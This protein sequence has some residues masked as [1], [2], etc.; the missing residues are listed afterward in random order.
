MVGEIMALDSL[1]YVVD[2]FGVITDQ[3]IVRDGFIEYMATDRMIFRWFSSVF[4]LFDEPDYDSNNYSKWIHGVIRNEHGELVIDHNIIYKVFNDLDKTYELIQ[5]IWLQW[6]L[7]MINPRTNKGPV[8]ESSIV[9]LNKLRQLGA[10]LMFMADIVNTSSE[11]RIAIGNKVDYLNV[12]ERPELDIFDNQRSSL[13]EYL[14]S[15]GLNLSMDEILIY[16]GGAIAQ[17]TSA[18]EELVH[19]VRSVLRD[20]IYTNLMKGLPIYPL[21][22]QEEAFGVLWPVAWYKTR[23]YEYY[24]ISDPKAVPQASTL[25]KDTHRICKLDILLDSVCGYIR[26]YKTVNSIDW[27]FSSQSPVI[28]LDDNPYVVAEALERRLAAVHVDHLE[29]FWRWFTYRTLPP[30]RFI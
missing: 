30:R 1:T 29:Q 18:E 25:A 6:S 22:R 3:S 10:K 26:E 17:R 24:Y 4:P 21:S 2:V 15:N 14:R 19:D 20:R 5:F 11:S 27:D 12:D 28:L 9:V 8:Y 23:L 16:D 13:F 7:Y